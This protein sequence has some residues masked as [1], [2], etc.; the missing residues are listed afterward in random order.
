VFTGDFNGDGLTDL[1]AVEGWG[2]TAAMSIYVAAGGGYFEDARP[3]PSVYVGGSSVAVRRMVSRVRV[4]DFNGDGRADIGLVEGW[5]GSANMSL[6]FSKGDSFAGRVDGPYMYVHDLEDL[7]QVDIQRVGIGDFNGDG[8]PDVSRNN[9]DGTITI[10]RSLN[11]AD[12]LTSA[13][14]AMGGT[15][16][17]AYVPSSSWS[18]T[19]LPAVVQTVSSLIQYDGVPGSG[20]ALTSYEYGAGY[21]DLSEFDFRGFGYARVTGPAGPNGER[22]AQELWFHQGNA[23]ID[24]F[25]SNTTN[26]VDPPGVAVGVLKGKPYLVR[27]TDLASGTF[28]ETQTTYLAD[29]TAPYFNPPAQIWSQVCESSSAC[30]RIT[31]TT[32]QYDAYGNAVRED[33]FGDIATSLDDRTVYRTYS[34]NTSAWIVGLPATETLYQGAGA[35]SL[36]ASDRI[37]DAWF[38]YDGTVGPTCTITGSSPTPTRGNL[39]RTVQWLNGGTNPETWTGF[40]PQGNP[41]CISD[42]DRRVTVFAWDLTRTFRIV[43][44]NAKLQATTT[45]YYGVNGVAADLG[46]YGQVKSVTDPNN[47]ST[48]MQYDALGRVVLERNALLESVSTAYTLAASGQSRV[49]KTSSGGPWMA[50][51]L[52]GF[53]RPYLKKTRGSATGR[54]IATRVRFNA[55]GTVASQTLPY[56]DGTDGTLP[57]TSFTYDAFGRRK[58]IVAVDGT[59]SLLCYSDLDGTTVAI[60]ASGHKRREVRNVRGDIVQVQTYQGT[61]DACTTGIGTPYTSTV[62]SYDRMGRLLSAAGPGNLLVESAYDTLGRKLSVSDPDLGNWTFGYSAAGDLTSR[63]DNASRTTIFRYDEVHRLYRTEYPSGQ[64]VTRS[65]DD[66]TKP[67]SVGRLS[68]LLD[69]SGSTTFEYDAL[70]REKARTYS[71]NGA[72]SYLTSQDFDGAGRLSRVGYPDG[73]SAYYRYDADAAL[74]KVTSSSSDTGCTYSA[75]S[76]AT[77]SGYNVLGQVAQVTFGNNVVRTAY[78]Y[79]NGTD[80]RLKWIKTSTTTDLLNL[81]YEYNPNGSISKITDAVDSTTLTLGYDGLDRLT[82]ASS[83]ALGNLSYAY[84]PLGNITAKEGVAYS[85]ADPIRIHAVTST[86]AGK[87]FAYDANGNMTS[88]GTRTLAYDDENR[89]TLIVAGAAATA[90]E[91]NGFGERAKKVGASGTTI[92]AGKT[93]EC[94]AGACTKSIYA[95]GQLIATVVVAT[96]ETRY[97][98]PDHLGSTRVVTASTG[99]VLEQVAYKPFG[100][101][102]SD[103][104]SGSSSRKYTGQILD[105]DTGLYFYNARYYDPSL[106]RFVSP[107]PVLPSEFDS[108]SLHRYSYVLNNPFRYTDPSGN[109]PRALRIAAT[110]ALFSAA[111]VGTVLVP[112]V[113]GPVLVGMTIGAAVG[114]YSSWRATGGGAIEWDSFSKGVLMGTVAGGASGFASGPLGIGGLGLDGFWGAVAEGAMSGTVAG[115][116]MGA[117]VGYQG[118]VGDWKG[119]FWNSVLVGAATGAVAGAA[120][121][122]LQYSL[123]EPWTGPPPKLGDVLK[124]QLAGDPS[125]MAS[126]KVPSMTSPPGRFPWLKFFRAVFPDAAKL[127]G[128]AGQALLAEPIAVGGAV[129]GA[130]GLASTYYVHPFCLDALGE[131]P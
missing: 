89:P 123:G 65:Y 10:F 32:V 53:A 54:V 45:Q 104:S 74:C 14:N 100:G 110:V 34:A 71:I 131:C 72:P 92:Y 55:S 16:T 88:D 66:P 2:Q 96:G 31:R 126:A 106:G 78:D 108:Q 119:G 95:G 57:G 46:R 101:T 28:R 117:S 50:T 29:G 86:T 35:P 83:G 15:T 121:G 79:Y 56:L 93:Y 9:A 25:D 49:E 73:S 130:A 98:H 69:P 30:G 38:Y 41:T 90:F 59:T 33:Q 116:A 37:A 80:R 7:G 42:P 76:Y 102:L 107:D 51:Y 103:T 109:T 60:D 36:L 67:Y 47:A 11:S 44:T 129:A 128:R 52:D 23:P 4:A 21:L 64:V 18:N 114:G 3:G 39:T 77:Y 27:E 97:Y 6:Y 85:Y 68:S 111:I 43:E 91:Y 13:S 70:G 87:V 118:G 12:L 22:R 63:R 58:T 81:T 20:S 94:T 127:A 5:G 26:D 24:L 75:S 115:A 82:S 61:F 112:P 99:A 124:P 120:M 48:T 40:D 19:R 17:I 125:K 84:D 105:S 122:G 8:Q 1:G 113:F 62:Y